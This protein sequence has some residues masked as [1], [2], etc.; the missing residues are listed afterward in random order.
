MADEPERPTV[1]PGEPDP[2]AARLARATVLFVDVVGFTDI[3]ESLGPE[4]AYF[5]VTGAVR[6][7]DEIA[8]RHGGAVDK[9]LSDCLL[10]MFGYPVP[11][12]DPACAA[13]AAAVEMREELR[14]YNASLDIPLR[15]V[16]GIN[17]G[18]LVAGDVRGR[19]AR[20]FNV[21]GDA[22]NVAARLKAKA[23]YGH[24]YVGPET[25]HESRELFEYRP[26]G[27]FAL[28]G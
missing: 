7:L 24:V 26:L 19:V 1:P 22:V 6:I 2:P 13:A 5:A 17:T 10:V 12:A 3:A 21:L 15:L 16:I 20:E 8:R 23:P 28:K 25:E 4:R 9:F 18:E 27:T 11:I 14:R